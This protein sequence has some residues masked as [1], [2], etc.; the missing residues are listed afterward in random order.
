MIACVCLCVD[1]VTIYQVLA[2]TQR[3]LVLTYFTCMFPNMI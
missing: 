2:L 3:Q 1:F